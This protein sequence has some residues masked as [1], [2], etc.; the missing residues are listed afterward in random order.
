MMII[1]RSTVE[2]P[3]LTRILALFCAARWFAHENEIST[4]RH[5][6]RAEHRTQRKRVPN[7][8]KLVL[9][10]DAHSVTKQSGNMLQ[11]T[12]ISLQSFY[13]TTRSTALLVG[14]K[15]NGVTPVASLGLPNHG[16]DKTSPGMRAL[17]RGSVVCT[18]L[19]CTGESII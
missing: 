10:G 9:S 18:T 6:P 16:S 5:V 2:H 4:I 7:A 3:L 13:T 11:S 17:V 15:H 12:N 19:V 8:I 1:H 14:T